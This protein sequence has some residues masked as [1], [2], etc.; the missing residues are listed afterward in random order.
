MNAVMASSNECSKMKSFELNSFHDQNQ[1]FCKKGYFWCRYQNGSSIFEGES[2]FD[3]V[4]KLCRKKNAEFVK[5]NSLKEM[6]RIFDNKNETFARFWSPIK[7][8]SSTEFQHGISMYDSNSYFELDLNLNDGD[9]FDPQRWDMQQSSTAYSV[10]S[11][12]TYVPVNQ[13]FIHYMYTNETRVFYSLRNALIEPFFVNPENRSNA[14]EA[15]LCNR[16]DRKMIHPG[17]FT[18]VLIIIFLIL[19]TFIYTVSIFC[20]LCQ[21]RKLSDMSSPGLRTQNQKT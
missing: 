19:I 20:N 14:F 18:L 2:V 8:I 1:A 5:P 21:F 15:C 16:I 9:A 7:R 13:S 12:R 11:G 3:D 17:I 4:D 10:L 6:Q